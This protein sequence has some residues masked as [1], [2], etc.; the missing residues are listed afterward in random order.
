M[1]TNRLLSNRT[2]EHGFTIVETM[3]ALGLGALG[4][5]ALLGVNDYLTKARLSVETRTTHTNLRNLIYQSLSQKISVCGTASANCAPKDIV[6]K[7]A[8][9]TN[10]LGKGGGTLSLPSGIL[11][12]TNPITI[13]D[14]IELAITSSAKDAT[15]TATLASAGASVVKSGDFPGPPNRQEIID[16][17]QYE[18]LLT[19]AIKSEDINLATRTYAG[20]VELIAHRNLLGRADVLSAQ[21]P[22]EFTVSTASGAITDCATRSME[23]RISGGQHT[24]DHCAD[25]G[26]V[27]VPS[28][29]G[30]LCRFRSGL[31][32]NGLTVA[33][34]PG[35]VGDPT[36]GCTVDTTSA[37]P[38][39]D[40]IPPCPP[41]ADGTPGSPDVPK[42]R[43]NQYC[44][45]A[46]T[47]ATPPAGPCPADPNDPT[48]G[49]VASASI[50]GTTTT[51][52]PSPTPSVSPSPT[53][54]TTPGVLQC[55]YQW[56]CDAPNVEVILSSPQGDGVTPSCRRYPTSCPGSDLVLDPSLRPWIETSHSPLVCQINPS[57][58]GTFPKPQATCPPPF[59][60]VN[61]VAHPEDAQWNDFTSNPAHIICF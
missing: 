37:S 40:T 5:Y 35:F 19:G 60:P 57:F 16:H 18:V 4:I 48:L 38:F 42:G 31:D 39:I 24:I 43:G 29:S 34:P 1:F 33:C 49:W 28:S 53:T 56:T 20:N 15:G 21:I 8:C 9:S 32:L 54:I 14:R 3:I 11:A 7:N 17:L 59:I 6:T 45:Y 27:T 36:T 58:T 41:L 23:R 44:D 22:I 61:T 51:S 13:A 12:S 30:T 52:S 2:G 47:T 10:V 46:G 50:P 25:A 55:A 26:G